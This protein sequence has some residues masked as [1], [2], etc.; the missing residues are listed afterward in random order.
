LVQALHPGDASS[1]TVNGVTFTNGSNGA[2]SGL[3][4]APLTLGA[5]AGSLTLGAEAGYYVDAAVGTYSANTG[6]FA[7]LS[8]SYQ[9]LISAGEWSNG[10]S[11]TSLTLTLNGL[12]ASQDYL[13]Q[14]WVGD[15]RNIMSVWT[16]TATFTA[17]NTSGTLDYNVGDA[18][19][20]VGQF[21]VGRFTADASTQN[22]TWTG[23]AG[24]FQ[25]Q[26]YQLRDVTVVPE[27]SV[28]ALLL[29]AA[30]FSLYFLRRR[31]RSV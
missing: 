3:I 26:G 11:A 28:N 23:Q 9:N 12:T 27:P 30:I 19:G 25:L 1:T 20:S 31:A 22:I 15:P 16:R 7:A 10:N 18:L 14:F 29:S 8:S 17:G 13:L 21:V 2:M 5:G 6:A 24:T 4:S